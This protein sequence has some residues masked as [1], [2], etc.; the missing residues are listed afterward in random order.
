MNA[1]TDTIRHRR[2]KMLLT[3]L[4]AIVAM[5]FIIVMMFM[6]ANGERR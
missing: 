4:G 3:I 6:G 1:D 5:P 2:L